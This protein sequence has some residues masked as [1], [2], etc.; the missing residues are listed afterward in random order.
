MKVAVWMEGTDFDCQNWSEQ[1]KSTIDPTFD[2]TVSLF[3][4]VP[5]SK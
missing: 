3:G 2:V 5:G 1:D 4:I